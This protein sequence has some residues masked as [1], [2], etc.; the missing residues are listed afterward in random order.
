MTVKIKVDDEDVEYTERK[1]MCC[2]QPFLSEGI[3]NRLC[4]PCKEGETG[5]DDDFSVT[6]GHTIND[7]IA[8]NIDRN[9]LKRISD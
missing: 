2:R 8:E 7:W 1:C 5:D 3:H 6:G 9:R 4:K